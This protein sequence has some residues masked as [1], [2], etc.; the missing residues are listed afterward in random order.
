MRVSYGMCALALGLAVACGGSE[1]GASTSNQPATTPQQ[2][3]PAAAAT[4]AGAMEAPSGEIDAALAGQGQGYFQ[5]KGCVGC[6]TVGSGKL[7]GPDLKGV[8]NRQSY[9]WIVAMITNPD[10]MLANDDTAKTLMGEM[11]GQRMVPMGVTTA[12]A[13]ALYEY[14]RQQGQ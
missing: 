1:N 8:T 5:S 6:H 4:Q 7:I 13:R 10:S 14:L 11:Q 2:T 3:Q 12:E 9:H